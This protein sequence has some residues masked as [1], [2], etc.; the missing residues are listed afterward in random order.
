MKLYNS[1]ARMPRIIGALMLREM[2]TTYGKS[3]GGYLW[4]VLEPAGGIAVLAIG[5]SLI[6]RSPP[7]GDNFL[8]FYATGV[9]P[10]TLY[11]DIGQKIAGSISFSKALLAYPSVTYIDAI[12]ARVILN[13]LTQIAVVYVI[14]SAIVLM[15]QPVLIV[16]LPTVMLGFF[17]AFTLSLSVGTFNCFMFS[18]FPLYKQL[19]AVLTRPLMLASCIFYTYESL[20]SAAQA[21]LWFNPL[22]HVVG[23]TRDGIF[24]QYD[25]TYVS[26]AYLVGWSILPLILGLVFLKRYYR[27]ILYET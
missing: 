20:P 17:F 2:A 19:W 8:L 3:P 23:I 11:M 5:F 12:L 24:W 6:M 9:L 16:D 18:Y 21:V 1:L 26:I 15:T 4:A 13:T 25:A 14:S 7:I 10:F 22:A 27:I